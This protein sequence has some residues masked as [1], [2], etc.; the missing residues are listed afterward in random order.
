MVK[1][2]QLMQIGALSDVIYVVDFLT[3]EIFIKIAPL[4][5]ESTVCTEKTLKASWVSMDLQSLMNTDLD[6]V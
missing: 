4:L 6:M 2:I 3:F 1:E 5:S